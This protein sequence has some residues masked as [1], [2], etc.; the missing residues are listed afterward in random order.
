ML[1]YR[2]CVAGF[3]MLAILP[4]AAAQDTHTPSSAMPAAEALKTTP[5][6][7]KKRAKLFP[8]DSKSGQPCE[9]LGPCGKCD[10]P[11]TAGASVKRNKADQ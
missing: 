8:D 3:A 10:C 4:S 9:F 1:T 6:P 7:T 5:A 11:A 2:I